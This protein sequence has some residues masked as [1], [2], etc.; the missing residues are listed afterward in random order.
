M[1][2]EGMRIAV[3]GGGISGVAHAHVLQKNGFE[4]VVFEKAA[5]VGGV[6]ALTY[7][8][9]RLQNLDFHYHLSDFAWP[10]RPDPHPTG[11]QIRAYWAAAVSAL[12]LDVR[13]EHTVV[14]CEEKEGGWIVTTEHR[15]ERAEHAF[16]YLVLAAGQY[17]E[18]KLRPAFEGEATFGGRIGTER[19]V[20]SLDD[21][22]GQR[23]VVVG[24]GKSALDMA[25]LAAT[26]G[27][28]AVHHVFRTPRW[29]LPMQLLGLHSSWVLFNR[30]GSVMMTS[31]AHPTAIERFLHRRLAP[32]IRV[33]WRSI[34]ALIRWQCRRAARGAG[35]E[36]AARIAKVLPPHELLPDLRSAAA[37]LPEAYLPSVA[38]GAIEPHHGE[39]AGFD[40]DGVRLLDGARIACDRVLLCVGSGSPRFPFLPER[41]R[42]IL[43]A[44]PDG[45]QLYRHLVHPRIP[46]IGFAGFNH[47]FMHVAAAELGAQWLA[48]RLR[49]ELELP[50]PEEME[51]SIAHVR[52]WKREHI[53]FE[54][55]RSVAINTRYQ[56]YLDILCADLGVSPYR[57]LPN[58]VA[59]VF[60]RYG[61]SDYAGVTEEV[62][63]GTK[64]PLKP[65]PLHT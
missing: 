27:A 61:A 36:G 5:E 47:G 28:A 57:K 8:G 37:L 29:A 18:G 51:R 41:Y 40:E 43:E 17:S 15:G 49:G 7:P 59:E 35:A 65:A 53:T 2:A 25:T 26:N 10:S 21:F 60:A 3:V 13:R 12:R 31:W 48:C 63:R 20:K 32:G 54:P 14:S 19:D 16:D 6:W 52:S 46:S 42:A 30:F 24:F 56:Q 39:L 50:A 11:E 34:A 58:V 64:R 33:F 23:V 55:S 4:V 44:E 62:R 38:K 1:A 9:V 22:A 45:P